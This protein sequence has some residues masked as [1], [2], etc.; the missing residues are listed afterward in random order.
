MAA[1]I[2]GIT[3][4]CGGFSAV[5]GGGLQALQTAAIASA[6]PF[7][8]VMLL[9][10]LGLYKALKNDWLKI[11]S[12]QMHN[13]SVQYA[14]TN[15]SWEERIEVLV[16]HPTEEDAR[17]FINNVATPA[18]SKVCQRFMSKGIVAD[19]EYI[20]GKVRLVV[21]NEVNLPF[22]YGVR[23]RCF[24]IVNPIGEELE[25]GNTSYYRAEVYLEQGGQH[26]DV[27]GYTEEQI[28]ADVVTQYE[29][30]LHYLH[31]SSADQGHV[32]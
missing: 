7:L 25:Q 18:L 32:A 24:E 5:I 15:I 28:L 11:N 1:S 12:V 31:L 19:L 9:M 2:L 4:R 30:Y 29:K 26:Y 13:T 10:C 8:V 23:L 27:M 17:V 21:S 14:K 16:S 20:E 22:V 3:S 6:M